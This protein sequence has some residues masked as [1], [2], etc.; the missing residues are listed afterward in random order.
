MQIFDIEIETQL[1]EEVRKL[2]NETP[3]GE[4]IE[5]EGVNKTQSVGPGRQ[6][7]WTLLFRF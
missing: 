3:V 7:P 1:R 2:Y 6:L 5:V 4:V